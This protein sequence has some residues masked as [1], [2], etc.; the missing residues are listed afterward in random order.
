MGIKTDL[1]VAPYHDDFTEDSEFY[2]VLFRPGYSIQARE[3]TTLQTML[4]NQ[5]TRFGK[6]MFKENSMVIPGQAT[7]DKEY[8]AVKLQSSFEY[9]DPNNSANTLEVQPNYYLNEYI[10]SIITGGTSGVAAKVV[11]AVQLT[12]DDPITLYVKYTKTGTQTALDGTISETSVFIEDEAI[13][14]DKIISTFA[15]NDNSAKTEL[16][17][18]T[19]IGCAASINSGVYF[20]RGHFV[21]NPQETI[22]LD[23]YT[24]FPSY[25]IGFKISELLENP[26]NDNSLLDNSTGATNFSAK[27]AHRLK[28]KLEFSAV[29]LDVI[30]E[31]DFVELIRVENGIIV[32]K[33]DRTDYA[34]MAKTMARRTYD[35]SGDYT[36]GSYK[37][38]LREHKND[39]YNGGLYTT[40][41]DESKA[42]IQISSGKSYVK[43]F[44][45]ENTQP[46]F[47]DIDKARDYSSKQNGLIPAKYGN[48]VIITNVSGM[49]DI[50]GS[51]AGITEHREVLLYDTLTVTG[52]TSSGNQIGSARIK[53]LE[54]ITGDIATPGSAGYNTHLFDI[55]MHTT[56]DVSGASNYTI[57]SKIKG[58]V[59]GATGYVISTTTGLGYVTLNNTSGKFINS[60]TL[61]SSNFN[62]TAGSTILSFIKWD[63]SSVKQLVSLVTAGGTNTFTADTDLNLFKRILGHSTLTYTAGGGSLGYGQVALEGI[64]TAF[65]EELLLGDIIYFDGTGVRLIVK[66]STVTDKDTA[67]LDLVSNNG[68]TVFAGGNTVVNAEL[69]RVRTTLDV[70]NNNTLLFPFPK[71]NIKSLKITPSTISDTIFEYKRQ[72]IGTADSNGTVSFNCGANETFADLNNN[73]YILCTED[74]SPAYI[75]ITASTTGIGTNSISITMNGTPTLVNKPVKLIATIKK[76]IGQEKTKT[77][78]KSVKKLI[79]S[80][81]STDNYGLRVFDDTIS[82]GVV[83]GFKLRAIYASASSVTTPVTPTLTISNLTGATSSTIVP[84]DVLTGEDSNALGV[85]ISFDPSTNVIEYYSTFSTFVLDEKILYNDNTATISGITEGD[86]NIKSHYKLDDGQ[87][88]SYYDIARIVRNKTGS[89]PNE[90]QLLII[91]DYFTH[92]STGDYFTVDSYENQIPRSEIPFSFVGST[93]YSLADVFDFRSSI[94]IPAATDNHFIFENRSFDTGTADVIN[95]PRINH[96]ITS[97]F[98]YYLS[99]IDHLYLNNSGSF[100]IQKGTSSEVPVAPPTINDSMKLCAISIPAFTSDLSSIKIVKIDNR[101]YTMRDVGDIVKRLEKLEYYTSLSLLESN[102]QNMQ[103]FDANG[104]D[105]FKSGFMIDNFTSFASGNWDHIDHNV[106]IDPGIGV[107]KPSIAIFDWPIRE[108]IDDASYMKWLQPGKTESQLISDKTA[109]DINRTGNNYR[110]TGPLITLPYEDVVF[111]S[112]IFASHVENVNPYAVQ[113]WTAGS[114]NLD[115]PGDTWVSTTQTRWNDPKIL[116]GNY[117]SIVDQAKTMGT[118]YNSWVN[119]GVS[120]S[121]TVST[122]QIS[123]VAGDPVVTNPI[124][125]L[126]AIIGREDIYDAGTGHVSWEVV[127]QLN[128]D[129]LEAMRLWMLEQPSVFEQLESDPNVFDDIIDDMRAGLSPENF[130]MTT[131]GILEHGGKGGPWSNLRYLTASTQ[132]TEFQTAIKT[133][134]TTISQPQSRTGFSYKATEEITSAFTGIT[135]IEGSLIPKIRAK[136]IEISANNMKPNTT[137]YPFFDGYEV[138]QYLE[139]SDGSSGTFKTD[140]SGAWGGYLNLPDG[141]FDTGVSTLRLTD[142]KN[143]I[144]IKGIVKTSAEGIYSTSGREVTEQYNYVSTRNGKLEAIGVDPETRMLDSTSSA[145][146]E[147]TDLINVGEA[148]TDWVRNAEGKLVYIDPLAQTFVVGN[149]EPGGV[150]SEQ[151]GI[152]VTKLDLY[153][154]SKDENLPVNVSIRTTLNGYPTTEVV[155]FGEVILNPV[156]VNIPELDADGNVKTEMVPTTFTFESPVHLKEGFEYCVVIISNSNEYTCWVSKLGEKDLNGNSISSNPHLGVFF[157]SQNASTW[158]PEQEVDLAFTLYKAKFDTS[159]TGVVRFK[160]KKLVDAFQVIPDGLEFKSG[161]NKIRVHKKNHGFS[162]ATSTHSILITGASEIISGGGVGGIPLSEI[163][164]LHTSITDI[165]TDSF[166]IATVTPATMTTRG[167]GRFMRSSRNIPYE[168]IHPTMRTVDFEDTTIQAT[169]TTTTAGYRD[170][171]GTILESAYNKNTTENISLNSDFMTSSPSILASHENELTSLAGVESLNLNLT[172]DS[173]NANV[174]PVIDVD[175]MSCKLIS[176]RINSVSSSADIGSLSEYSP[177]TESQGDNNLSIYITREIRVEVPASSLRTMFAGV[178]EKDC[179]LEVLYKIRTPGSEEIFDEMGWEYFNIDGSADLELPESS[180]S[181]EFYDRLYTVDDLPEFTSFAIK[182]VMKSTNPTKQPTIRDFRTIAMA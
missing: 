40:I 133:D 174:S 116:A 132:Q 109:A 80:S 87:R 46:K 137:I 157:K 66:V 34:V 182:V 71:R 67:V 173:N 73:N 70:G 92:S 151:G 110:K 47:I 115:P 104:F 25:K 125:Q 156:D 52:G 53:S 16:L 79:D 175:F 144:N 5:I 138:S 12:S 130:V 149:N 13:S 44:E 122:T 161:Q 65:D 119:T 76:S 23:K 153:F 123:S 28:L 177:S 169:V 140:P 107:L 64:G 55:Q 120:T 103:I 42:V 86:T 29:K 100:I 146:T 27:G 145:Q 163:N 48:S 50:V 4:Q 131:E 26:E 139:N 165:E 15:A 111:T 129:K 117:D 171:N 37:F 167:G 24:N 49:P 88:S 60:E 63:I 150:S 96:L 11:N 69:T 114:L 30:P 118:V 31:G 98:E 164:K 148:T 54:Y 180:H 33:V 176:H 68:S 168:I 141:I 135:K 36:L 112:Q 43:G 143:N 20:I 39:G 158:T 41:G 95:P 113:V 94:D 126:I 106:S 124:D 181:G 154:Q 14:S 56:I 18:A 32:Q 8:H 102:T 127:S 35:E 17:N 62:D 82:L 77:I 91:F 59:S 61:I 81:L 136:K 1:N 83:D 38:N 90:Q 75:D 121:D 7:L 84:G 10:G 3:L 51:D 22:I 105:R 58:S 142:S 85:V 170:E 128:E 172:I 72:Y 108:Y 152:F 9:I 74:G 166:C 99:R 57:G 6:H 134:I 179:G 45:V 155:P 97:D 159:S 89:I 21:Q 160:N 178:V 162:P 101:R 19:A 93:K 78:N 147:S 2:R